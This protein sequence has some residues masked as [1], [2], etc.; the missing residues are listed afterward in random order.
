MNSTIIQARDLTKV[1]RL[2]AKPYYRFLD[3]FGLLPNKP[4]LFSEHVAV[5]HINLEIKR[6]EKVA[7]IGRNGAGKSTLLKLITGVIEPTTGSIDVASRIHALLQIG[8]G[9]HPEF[10][11][12]ENVYSYLAQLGVDGGEAHRKVEEIIEFAELEEYIDQPIKTYSTGMGV[13]LM[14]AASTAISPDIL[15]LDEVLGVGDA[16]FSQ[17]S[18]ERIKSMCDA[19]QATLLLVSHDLYS[20]MNICNRFVWIERGRIVADGGPDEVVHR[21]EASIRDQEE[22]RLR[23]NHIRVLEENS[24]ASGELHHEDIIIYGHIRTITLQPIDH[25]LPIESMRVMVEGKLYCEF[26]LTQKAQSTFGLMLQPG[27]GNWGEAQTIDGKQARSFTVS[28]S[29]YHRAPFY[30]LANQ[31][32]LNKLDKGDVEVTLCYQDKSTTQC[33]V[34]L[35]TPERAY[36]GELDNKGCGQWITHSCKLIQSTNAIM[37]KPP[38]VRWGSQ[39]FAITD[40]SFLDENGNAKLIYSINDSMTV[41]M[42]YSIRDNNFNQ[43]PVIAVVFIKGGTNLRTHRFILDKARFDYS[44]F[45]DGV[46]EVTANPL[47]LGPGEYLINIIVMREGGFLKAQ[48]NNTFYTANDQLLDAHNRAY[49]ISI[50]KD[51]DNNLA[52]DVVFFHPCVWKKDGVVI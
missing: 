6:G 15:V 5:D 38:F 4:G 19:E 35:I 37:N 9:F 7:F 25:D 49:K 22:K 17:K 13:R 23:I 27:E 36:Q 33:C 18:Y 8:T 51:D 42:R 41:R 45:R 40:V 32:F 47:M 50:L 16:Y 3:M 34:E 46:I 21:Y 14:F 1:Y 48:R 31:H 2:Y 28:G 29:I 11:G 20:A 24:R 30:V 44:Q 43:H 26:F 10:T 12:R 52:N 39:S